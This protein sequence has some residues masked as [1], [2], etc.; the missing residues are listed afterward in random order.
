MAPETPPV[1]ALEA[2][3]I[4]LEDLDTFAED[5]TFDRLCSDRTSSRAVR[6]ALQEAIQASID[7]GEMLLT[8]TGVR[9]PETYRQ[10]F[11]ELRDHLGLPE[12]L[13][14]EMVAAAG[15]RNVLVHLYTIVDLEQVFD[16]LQAGRAHLRAYSRWVAERMIE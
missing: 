8:R 2:L 7:L 5:V 4:A 10:V 16:A 3:R 11:E 15:M 12:D 13:A 9:S 1:S 6:H 14:R